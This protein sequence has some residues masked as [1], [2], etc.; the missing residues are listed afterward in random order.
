MKIRVNCICP[1]I[2]PTEMTATIGP[3]GEPVMGRMASK[4]FQRSTLGKWVE[5]SLVR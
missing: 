5:F 1:G 4:A 3:D 2:F